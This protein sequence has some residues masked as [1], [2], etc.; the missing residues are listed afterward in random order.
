M[1]A[2]DNF[3]GDFDSLKQYSLECEFKDEVNSIDGVVYPDICKDIPESILNDVIFNL[4]HRF[5]REPINPFCFMRKSSKGVSVPHKYHTD[6]SMGRYSMM[7]YLQD[8]Q[9]AGTGFAIHEPT[10]LSSAP[11]F[12]H[13]LKE[14]IKDCNDDS[15]WKIYNTIEM[16]QN[17]AVIFDSRLFHVA[18]PI[19]GFGEAREDSR[20]VFTCFFS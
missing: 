5:A 10:G 16:K 19:G 7:I 6:N 17:R 14:T 4:T 18:L 13:Q 9:D 1:I 8:R 3:L 2:I 15:K 20:I 11:V 12:E